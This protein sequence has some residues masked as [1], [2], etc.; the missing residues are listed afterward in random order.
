MSIR[1]NCRQ[2]GK[3]LK[4]A[5]QHAGKKA[6]CTGCGAALVVPSPVAAE[7]PPVAAART[8]AATV[9]PPSSRTTPDEDGPLLP[10]RM[11]HE[12]E[13]VDMTAMVDVTFFLLIFFMT[14]SL[15]SLAAAK[16][17][18]S[19]DPDKKAAGAVRTV[20]QIEDDVDYVVV[21][22]DKDN[23]VWVDDS[24]A[25]SEQDLLS[26]LRVAHRG[27]TDAKGANKMMVLPSGDA[28]T[29]TVVMVLDAGTTAG[30]EDLRLGSSQDD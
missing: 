14:A 29:E 26:K 5:P 22:I 15:Q 7:P 8:V 18:P 28:R 10:P 25:R 19:P 23:T 27:T 12:D 1:F 3:L 4:A 6:K 20:Q 17:I 2:C 24:E 9:P 16:H 21:R 13:G 30:I 11:P